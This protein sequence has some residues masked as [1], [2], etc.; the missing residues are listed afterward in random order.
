MNKQANIIQRLISSTEPSQPS[1]PPPPPS[2]LPTG[3]E[4]DIF[5]ITD[6]LLQVTPF[7]SSL[8]QHRT[9]LTDRE[10]D[11]LLR[12]TIED[13]EEK[14]ADFSHTYIPNTPDIKQE[15]KTE[16]YDE[17]P[18]SRFSVIAGLDMPLTIEEKNILERMRIEQTTASKSCCPVR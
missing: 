1:P 5:P 10:L 2:A 4:K 13:I 16:H 18:L 17:I 12:Q 7:Y 15:I 8:S 3:S 14:Q 9:G 6:Q 11:D